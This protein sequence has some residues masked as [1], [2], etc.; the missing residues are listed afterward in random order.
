[1]C[2]RAWSGR[3]CPRWPRF[4]SATLARLLPRSK[5]VGGYFPPLSSRA[6]EGAA[7]HDG[8]IV[9]FRGVA[10]CFQTGV[11]DRKSERAPNFGPAAFRGGPSG[12]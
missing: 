11:P 4:L 5:A 10:H 9:I 2:T 3:H 7:A 1:M 8:A 6:S 12:F